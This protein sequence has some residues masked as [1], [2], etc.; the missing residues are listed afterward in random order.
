MAGALPEELTAQLDAF[1]QSQIYSDGG[2]QAL[3]APGLVLLVDTPDGRYLEAAGVANLA[4]G[5]PMVA[6]DI[7]EIGSNTKSM[8]IV[9]LMQLVE[10]GVLSLDDP[11]SKWLPDQA[12]KLPNGD[13][14]T[15]RQMAQHTA[16]L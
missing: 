15:I 13:Q 10:E 8:T 14:I 4:D 7:L 2:D 3:A 1:L 9:L 6:D 5:R 11:L 16:G 12:A